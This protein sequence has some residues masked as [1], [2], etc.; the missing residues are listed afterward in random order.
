MMDDV[1]P[2]NVRRNL[3]TK[4]DF[5]GFRDAEP[6]LPSREHYRHVRNPHSRSQKRVEDLRTIDASLDKLARADAIMAGMAGQH[7]LRHRHPHYLRTSCCSSMFGPPFTS[8]LP[9]ESA[10]LPN[11]NLRPCQTDLTTPWCGGC[12]MGPSGSSRKRWIISLVAKESSSWSIL[13]FVEGLP[14]LRLFEKPPYRV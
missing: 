13:S 11:K 6:Q 7:L 2:H 5:D 12:L 14:S 1:F 8:R 9:L 10:N 3:P 4:Q